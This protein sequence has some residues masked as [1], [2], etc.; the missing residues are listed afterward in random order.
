MQLDFFPH[1][2]A[3]GAS[4]KLDRAWS[5]TVL[6][7]VLNKTPGQKSALQE[8]FRYSATGIILAAH[9]SQVRA[10]AQL[11]R[12]DPGLLHVQDSDSGDKYPNAFSSGRKTITSE[13]AAIEFPTIRAAS[14]SVQ[15]VKS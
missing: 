12:F 1:T 4:S 6:P 8:Y 5:Q 9:T 2:T 15:P 7:L 10:V 14:F 11:W 3:G 13:E